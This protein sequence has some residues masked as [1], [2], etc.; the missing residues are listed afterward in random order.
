MSLSSPFSYF[1]LASLPSLYIPQFFPR[2]DT[3]NVTTMT[4]MFWNAHAFNGDLSRWDTSNVTDMDNMFRDALAFNKD[5]HAWDASNVTS[6]MKMFLECPIPIHYK[7]R[8]E[9]CE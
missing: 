7:P 4:G 5:I 6:V 2:W 9:Y 8:V 3:S 1:Y